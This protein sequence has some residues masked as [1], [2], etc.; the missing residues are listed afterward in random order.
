MVGTQRQEVGALHG[1]AAA[2]APVRVRPTD[3]GADLRELRDFICGQGPP[4]ATV[5]KSLSG[6]ERKWLSGLVHVA[7]ALGGGVVLVANASA[8]AVTYGLSAPLAE[9]S[10][11]AGGAILIDSTKA[12]WKDL[13]DA[14][15]A[16]PCC[17]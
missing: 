12:A 9:L 7:A 4:P 5:E 16:Q 6:T 10:K 8:I 3:P 14:P 13:K 11:A 2:P 17:G 1:G 15:L